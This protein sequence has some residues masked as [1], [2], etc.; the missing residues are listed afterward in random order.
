MGDP[1]GRA[2]EGCV[3][4]PSPQPRPCAV[5]K[6]PILYAR[7]RRVNKILSH[8]LNTSRRVATDFSAARRRKV[9]DISAV[10]CYVVNAVQFHQSTEG[11]KGMASKKSAKKGGAKKS[12]GKKGSSGKSSA[13]K[14]GAKKGGAKKGAS[15]GGAKKGGAKK[16]GAKKSGASK[17]GA[18]KGGAKKGGAKKSSSKK[19]G[20]K[21][22]TKAKEIAGDVLIGAGMG[23]LI[24]A[25]KGGVEQIEDKAG[26]EG[27][28]KTPDQ[29][30]GK[31]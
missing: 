7:A 20:S 9:D 5:L 15:K 6:R 26:I 24:G 21:L 2:R 18:K 10:V 28:H 13:K 16:G 14:G 27:E 22:L 19:G 1:C 31:K 17:G 4:G 30:G 23:A 8:G 25:V 11:K 3:E 12:G 29:Q